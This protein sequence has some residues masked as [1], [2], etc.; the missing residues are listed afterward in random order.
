[1]SLTSKIP[2]DIREQLS[3]DPFM[4]YCIAGDGWDCDGR[5]EWQHALTYAGRR[6]NELWAILPMC[7]LHH[8]LQAAFRPHQEA[9][10]VKRIA[11]FGAEA[12]FRAK[13]PRS[14]LFAV[15]N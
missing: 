5:I 2:P 1:M 15:N 3:D 9:A 12:E 7:S 8:R 6:V 13:Y 10:M 11:H 14:D 4:T